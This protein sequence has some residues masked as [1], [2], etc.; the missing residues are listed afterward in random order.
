MLPVNWSALPTQE[1]RVAQLFG[2][3]RENGIGPN[4]ITVPV[5]G[6]A[7][8]LWG[9]FS[10][11]SRESRPSWEHR[12]PEIA[13]DTVIAA[14]YLHT[15]VMERLA[16]ESLA[17]LDAVTRRET[18]ALR[19]AAEGWSAKQIA[20]K[21]SIAPDTVQAHLDSARHKLGALNR[22]HAIVKA[23]RSGIIR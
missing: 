10:G 6:P 3:A 21:M 12:W 8:G 23:I 18:E 7:N 4:G 14:N 5:R 16:P 20:M 22:S 17:D 13:R 9:L 15:K 1:I 19:W 2:E 11:C